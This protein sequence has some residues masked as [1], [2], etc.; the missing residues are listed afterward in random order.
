MANQRAAIQMTPA[1][2]QAFLEERL[3]MAFASFGP[4]GSVHL[5]GM[6]YGFLDGKLV[7]E[8]KAK[9]QKAQNLRRDPRFTA[10]LETGHDYAELRGVEMVGRATL[11]DDPGALWRIGC[12][13]FERYFGP[14]TKETEP[15]VERT[16]RNRVGFVLD[17]E[18]TVTWD[19]RKL[20]G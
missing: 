5:V 1:E 4:D 11:V 2:V 14:V 7:I 18:R 8:T 3:T 10:L 15:V 6:W 17:V 16:L 20:S 12:D 9:S 13:V 19:H